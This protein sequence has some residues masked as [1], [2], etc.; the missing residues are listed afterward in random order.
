MDR[1]ALRFGES[2]GSDW[3]MGKTECVDEKDGWVR[4]TIQ[5][6]S[7]PDDRKEHSPKALSKEESPKPARKRNMWRRF[8]GLTGQS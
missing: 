7:L 3:L 2:V 6:G 8:L 4:V 5:A 1:R